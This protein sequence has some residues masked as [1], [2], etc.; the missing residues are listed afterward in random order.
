[1][2]KKTPEGKIPYED[3]DQKDYH[4]QYYQ[5]NKEL[6][7]AKRMMAKETIVTEDVKKW[8]EE[9]LKDP[10]ALYPFYDPSSNRR[11]GEEP[12]ISI[13]DSSPSLSISIN[14]KEAL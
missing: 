6:I 10:Y 7:R 3:I 13:T 11:Y 9:K 12:D 14:S 2:P 8:K 5:K 4:R 1:M